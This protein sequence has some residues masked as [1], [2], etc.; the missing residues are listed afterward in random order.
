[1]LEKLFGALTQPVENAKQLQVIY[2]DV[3][4]TAA[5]TPMSINDKNAFFG[6]YKALAPNVKT[7]DRTILEARRRQGS[8]K[9]HNIPPKPTT[10]G[11]L[12]I[13]RPTAARTATVTAPSA[14][15]PMQSADIASAVQSSRPTIREGSTGPA[16]QEWQRIIGVSADGKFGPNTKAKTIEW[17]KRNG[18]TADG[19]VGPATWGKALM[20][21]GYAPAPVKGPVD[22][23]MD[24]LTITAPKPT[25]LVNSN[26]IPIVTPG[27][28]PTIRQGSTGPY[29]VEWQN[30][31]SVTPDGK[32][33]P[34]TH[35]ATVAWQRGRGL[36]ADGIVGPATWARAQSESAAALMLPAVDMA[37]AAAQAVMGTT[38]SQ[39]APPPSIPAAAAAAAA[40][41]QN[42]GAQT[43][44]TGGANPV[45][46]TP[47][48]NALPLWMVIA[49]TLFG[50]GIT[51]LTFKKLTGR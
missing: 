4:R 48:K 8:F 22:M 7:Q 40:A 2:D 28:K 13:T 29:V 47:P 38:A 23:V 19:V 32:F 43:P 3:S 35:T 1:M 27:I 30:I 11:V 45:M 14:K 9:A 6:W 15:A 26:P 17:Q 36:S 10:S 16:V 20:G 37:T 44:F 41:V 18:L 21:A 5:I 39:S 24:V 12:G 31:L 25:Q 50:G 46:P 33:G 49:G 51:V 34:A 42:P